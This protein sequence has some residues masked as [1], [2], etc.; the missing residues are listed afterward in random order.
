M[1]SRDVA[2]ALATLPGVDSR[3]WVAALG[4]LLVLTGCGS[5]DDVAAR[6][7]AT[8]TPSECE[9]ALSCATATPPGTPP[10]EGSAFWDALTIEALPGQLKAVGNDVDVARTSAA[11]RVTVHAGHRLGVQAV[12]EGRTA[13]VV[14]TVPDTAAAVDLTCGFDGKPAEVGAV[15]PTAVS[16]AT[17]YQVSVSA[18]A[19]ARWFTTFYEAPA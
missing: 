1:T 8:P 13:V 16:A 7:T 4:A 10:P 11:F 6:S 19:P 9:T 18:P 12:C 15:D 17:T 5:S 2:W 3:T 14:Q